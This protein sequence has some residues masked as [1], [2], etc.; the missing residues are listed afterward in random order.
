MVLQLK[1]YVPTCKTDVLISVSPLHADINFNR[2]MCKMETGFWT[3]E[4]KVLSSGEG[5]RGS[6]LAY[7]G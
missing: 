6:S 2:I 3:E 1:K 4:M 7:T 5:G